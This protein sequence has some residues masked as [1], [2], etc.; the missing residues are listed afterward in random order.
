MAGVLALLA[1]MDDFHTQQ[2]FLPDNPNH[3]H[4]DEIWIGEGWTGEEINRFDGEP[5]ALPY[6]L[7]IM[8]NVS[9]A[10]KRLA[11]QS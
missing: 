8:R 1:Y 3:W 11:P 9:N 6:N 7:L 2:F 5:L 10:L 4:S